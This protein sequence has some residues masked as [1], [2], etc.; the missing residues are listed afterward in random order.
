M[1]DEAE[2]GSS[3][4]EEQMESEES[5]AGNFTFIKINISPVQTWE[6]YMDRLKNA[7]DDGH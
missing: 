3:S 5:R 4:D 6:E 7:E 2:V 1:D